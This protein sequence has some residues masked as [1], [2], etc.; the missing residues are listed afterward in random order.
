MTD[1]LLVHPN[2]GVVDLIG[3]DSIPTPDSVITTYGGDRPFAPDGAQFTVLRVEPITTRL[4]GRNRRAWMRCVVT[5]RT[6]Q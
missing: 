2:R 5:E 1:Y 3:L 6:G 4:V